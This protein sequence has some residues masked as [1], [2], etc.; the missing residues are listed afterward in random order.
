MLATGKLTVE[1][2]RREVGS[3]GHGE[4]ERTAGFSKLRIGK[5]ADTPNQSRSG[6]ELKVVEVGSRGVEEAVVHGQDNLA[7]NP[8]NRGR[9]RGGDD[10]VQVPDDGSAG[11]H[12]DR[13]DLVAGQIR[14][15]Y[16]SAPGDR[17]A[18]LGRETPYRAAQSTSSAIPLGPRSTS[19]HATSSWSGG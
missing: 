2:R 5:D 7:G 11:H 9:N 8:S 13:T 1:R 10:R 6:N 16:L 3:A 15:P 14:K 12:H 4:T 18:H 19:A 17:R